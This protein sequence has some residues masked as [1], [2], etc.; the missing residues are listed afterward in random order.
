[1]EG[2]TAYT[3]DSEISEYTYI[4]K[5]TKHVAVKARNESEALRKAHGSEYTRIGRDTYAL[6]GKIKNTEKESD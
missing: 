1:M 3:V 4:V 2:V 6:L 5:I